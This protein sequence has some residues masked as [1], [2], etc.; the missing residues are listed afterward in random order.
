MTV[1][2]RLTLLAAALALL[3]GCQMMPRGQT[4]ADHCANPRH[5]GEAVC[6]LNVEI[7][8]N[9]TAIASLDM[10]LQDAE[11]L[12]RQALDKADYAQRTANSALVRAD[13]AM[14]RANSALA[15]SNMACE[16]RVLQKTD[17]GSCQPGWTLMSCTQ[18][19]YTHAAGGLSILREIDDR[20]CRFNTRVLEM[21]ARCCRMGAGQRAELA[22]G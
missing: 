22:G 10:R 2:A 12:A 14:S 18:T 7:D 16:T 13:D 9:R 11:A 15:A 1:P 4:V 21:Q 20:Q 3:A 5:A 19:R 17:T 8:G 6:Q